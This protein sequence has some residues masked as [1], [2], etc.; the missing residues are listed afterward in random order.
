MCSVTFSSK[1]SPRQQETRPLI[2]GSDLAVCVVFLWTRGNQCVLFSC[3]QEE[4]SVCCGDSCGVAWNLLASAALLCEVSWI[5]VIWKTRG[6]LVCFALLFKLLFVTFHPIIMSLI[7]QVSYHISFSW[8]CL[9]NLMIM[10]SQPHQNLFQHRCQNIHL[11]KKMT[12]NA[13]IINIISLSISHFIYSYI[14]VAT[15]VVKPGLKMKIPSDSS[16]IR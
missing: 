7:T 5:S 15:S 14:W 11:E 10:C 13:M 2:T 6:S 16:L 9:F 4:T 8:R 1:I 12:L 3:E